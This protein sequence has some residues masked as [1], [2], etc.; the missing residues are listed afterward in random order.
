MSRQLG[1]AEYERVLPSGMK[2]SASVSSPKPFPLTTPTTLSDSAAI[3]M[4]YWE[5]KTAGGILSTLAIW[6]ARLVSFQQEAVPE[7][8]T[9]AAPQHHLNGVTRVRVGM[10][11][12]PT[13]STLNVTGGPAYSSVLLSSLPPFLEV[14]PTSFCRRPPMSFSRFR[15]E[16]QD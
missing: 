5:G 9:I 1:T 3:T 11:K 4:G 2:L 7:T 15:L 6:A 14:V 10:R 13:P 12:L 16:K 8:A